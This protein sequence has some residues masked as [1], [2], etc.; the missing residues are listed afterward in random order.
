M[1][2]SGICSICGRPG[3][4]FSCMLC[5]RLVCRNCYDP[6]NMVCVSCKV[7]KR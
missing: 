2:M 4:M 7:G 6:I 3:A 1:E 5:G